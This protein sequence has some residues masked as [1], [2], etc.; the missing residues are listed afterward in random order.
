MLN[1]KFTYLNELRSDL[2]SLDRH[3]L[4]Y[5]LLKEELSKQGYW[6]NKQRGNASKGGY[7]K[8]ANKQVNEYDNS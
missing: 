1:G 5:K 3:S 7:A 8:Y 6:K 2:M 4:L